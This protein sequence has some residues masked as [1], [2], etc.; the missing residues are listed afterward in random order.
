[1]ISLLFSY[2]VTILSL[3]VLKLYKRVIKRVLKLPNYERFR[4][5]TTSNRVLIIL[6]P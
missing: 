1:M 2:V 4:A 3:R 6:E 5:P